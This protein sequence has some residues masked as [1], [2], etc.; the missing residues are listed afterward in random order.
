MCNPSKVVLSVVMATYNNAMNDCLQQAV[1]SVLQQTFREFELIICDDGSTDETWELLETF[2]IRDSRIRIIRNRE[3]RK[4]GYARNQAIELSRGEYIAIMDADDALHPQ[5]FER[6]IA[7]LNE[8]PEYG[9]VG[10]YGQFFHATIGDEKEV[11]RLL[12]TPLAKD[13]LFTLP[14]IHASCMFRREVILS[15]GGYDISPKR[16]RVE[17]YDMLLRIYEAGYRGANIP[18]VL[19]YIRRDKNQYKRRKYRYRFNEAAMKYQ[20]WHSLD[21]GWQGLI[22]TIKPL[23]VGLLPLRWI[24]FFQSKYYK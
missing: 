11:Y 1:D 16:L 13:L 23:I 4:A 2:A 19:Y 3:N 21:I 24:K 10:C 14:F 6:Q 15:V 9:F 22:C 18:E 8:H 20:A 12:E 7:F 17:D 5:R